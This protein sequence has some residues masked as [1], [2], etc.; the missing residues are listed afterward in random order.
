M[1]TAILSV[2]SLSVDFTGGSNNEPLRALDGVSFNVRRGRSLGVAG[3]SGCGKS[4]LARVLCGLQEPTAGTVALHGKP[5]PPATLNRHCQMV[6]QDP[7]SSLN[8]RLKIWLQ[9][10][11]PLRGLKG[12]RDTSKLRGHAAAL[13]SKVGLEERHLDAWP[14]QFSGGQ[15]Q[16]IAL[17]RAMA[18]EPD[19]IVADE[20][21]SSLDVSSQAGMIAVLE[22]V[23]AAGTTLVIIS[24]D[25]S[26]FH[27]LA[28]D[29]AVM[30][31]G[32]IVEQGTTSQVLHSPEAGYTGSLLAAVPLLPVE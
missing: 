9:I 17:A 31:R 22:E 16:R 28:D 15:R 30:H 12:V 14:H 20:P 18:I 11:E 3:E 7:F 2:D 13:L 6:F 23:K 32:R 26:H 24:H 25:F 21:L 27:S 1:N 29:V 5:A 8:P 4:T 10:S 19:I